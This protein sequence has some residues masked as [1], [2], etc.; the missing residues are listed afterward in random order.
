MDDLEVPEIE[1]FSIM[2]EITKSFV[3]A[4]AV[5]AGTLLGFLVVGLVTNEIDKKRKRNKKTNR[6]SR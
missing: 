4:T 2:K 3:I 1:K 5:T 6:H